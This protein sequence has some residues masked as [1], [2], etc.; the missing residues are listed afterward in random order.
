L[1][2]HAAPT[3]YHKDHPAEDFPE[4]ARERSRH[5]QRQPL[6]FDSAPCFPY[7]EKSLCPVLAENA[8]LTVD[9]PNFSSWLAGLAS[10][11]R[12]QTVLLGVGIG[13]ERDRE[14]LRRLNGAQESIIVR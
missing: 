10:T 12:T 9:R 6:D 5:A 8:N 11:I 2:H 7:P 3:A 4:E 1:V 14:R 13:P